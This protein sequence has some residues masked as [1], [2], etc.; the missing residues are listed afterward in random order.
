MTK[1]RTNWQERID[2]VLYCLTHDHD[3]QNT[4][5][6]FQVS[7]QQVYKW[8]KKYEE[9]GE[10][11]LKDGRGRKKAT[12]E[13]SEADRQ[14]LAIKKLE[15]ENERLRVE[16]TLLKK[17]QE[18][19]GPHFKLRPTRNIYLAI[20]AVHTEN[21]F[22]VNTLCQI[23]KI[24]RSSYYKWLKC[25][26]SSNEYENQQLVNTMISLYEQIEDIY[27][28]CKLNLLNRELTVEKSI[29]KWLT[30]VT[31]FRYEKAQ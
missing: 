2:I 28:Y 25:E 1:G 7:Y 26:V 5:E 13:L 9:G 11:A 15:Y 18:L 8:V 21:H 6:T 22:S 12:E 23:A 31:E 19:K 20:Q 24:P 3:Y 29:N 16:N 4:S 17:L 27:G 10:E 30:D 14:K